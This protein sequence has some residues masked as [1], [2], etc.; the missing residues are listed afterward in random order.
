MGYL[1]GHCGI[2]LRHN[3]IAFLSDGFLVLSSF[4]YL[5]CHLF[6]NFYTALP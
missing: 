5:Y 3:N 4:P 6:V 1:W 2:F